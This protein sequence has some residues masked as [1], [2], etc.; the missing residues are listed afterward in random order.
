MPAPM[1]AS[2]AVAVSFGRPRT[3]IHLILALVAPLAACSPDPSTPAHTAPHVA[4]SAGV[5]LVTYDHTPTT[6]APFQL[7]PEPRYRHGA[8]PG[9][10]A[11]Q[12]VSIGRLLPDGNAVVY[13]PWNAELVVLGPDGTTHEALATEGEGPGEVS[14]VA[15]ILPLGRD[16]ILIADPGLARATLFVGDSVAGISA[17]PRGAR[18]E[19][20]GIGAS[21]ELLLATVVGAWGFEG[22]WLPG[23][24]ARFDAESGALDTV[25]AFDFWPR[26]PPGMQRNLIGAVGEVTVATGHFIQTRSDKAEVTWR[27]PDGTVTQIVRWQGEPA[28][29]TEEWL[30]PVEAEHRMQVRMHSPDLSEAR[31]A[32]ITRSDMGAYRAIIGRPMPLF[33]SPFA[34]AEGRVWLPSYKPGGERHSMAPYTVIAPDGEWLGTVEAARGFHILDAGAGLVLGVERDEM[35]VES[36]VVFELILG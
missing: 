4:D 15:A 30:A 5:R 13:D 2:A 12:E 10:Y 32:E 16:S 35:D 9:D 23:H 27:L 11:F 20:E 26:T 18:L 28:L 31:V 1:A 24:M 19:V 8:N 36:V 7:A 6:A 29:L 21:G 3:R 22:E 33:G 25:A 34:D 17:L 14:F